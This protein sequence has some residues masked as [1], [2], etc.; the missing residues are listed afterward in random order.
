[1]PVT[2]ASSDRQSSLTFNLSQSIF[3]SRFIYLHI[4]PSGS[5]RRQILI[6]GRADALKFVSVTG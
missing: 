1:M 3:I 2:H 5:R 6:Y 4:A